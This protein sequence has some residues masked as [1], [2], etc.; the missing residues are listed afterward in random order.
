[1]SDVAE[2]LRSPF[3]VPVAG[4]FM[5]ATISVARIWSGVRNREIR[6]QERLAM[7]AQGLQPE[8]DWEDVT[9]REAGRNVQDPA[10]PTQPRDGSR[11]RLTGIIL[12]AVGLGLMGFFFLLAI[13][14]HTSAVL[15][16]TAAGIIPLAIGVGYLADA[17]MK[18]RDYDR[19]LEMSASRPPAYA[20]PHVSSFPTPSAVPSSMP[21][22]G[23]TPAQASDWRPLH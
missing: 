14:V 9:L 17:R 6:S 15:A 13:A 22:Q 21:P 2:V 5:I 18:R 10:R 23:L 19:W 16:G 11:Q 3:V 4:C 1:M 8:P 12:C 20:P 7:I